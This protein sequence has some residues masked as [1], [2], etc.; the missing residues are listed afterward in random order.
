[1]TMTLEHIAHQAVAYVYQPDLPDRPHNPAS[2]LTR[3]KY[4][5]RSYRPSQI[6][7]TLKN[8]VP[9][10]QRTIQRSRSIGLSVKRQMSKED[11]NYW[12]VAEIYK[13]SDGR[14]RLLLEEWRLQYK[15]PEPRSYLP[16]LE[17]E[18]LKDW[19][20]GFKPICFKALQD[21]A[22]DE[23][24]QSLFTK[25]PCSTLHLLQP[26]GLHLVMQCIEQYR[27]EK[28]ESNC[29]KLLAAWAS[30]QLMPV[31]E[32]LLTDLQAWHDY[33]TQE[34]LKLATA[35][36]AYCN[37][38]GSSRALY[39][40]L[41]AQPYLADFFTPVKVELEPHNQQHEGT[42]S[43]KPPLIEL[44]WKKS[45]PLT[46]AYTLPSIGHITLQL[47]KIGEQGYQSLEP[48]NELEPLVTALKSSTHAN[49][50]MQYRTLHRLLS[51][52]LTL[53]L[54]EAS[55]AELAKIDSALT[56]APLHQQLEQWLA[57]SEQGI[58]ND[59]FDYVTHAEV[60][61]DK[62]PEIVAHLEHLV[63]QVTSTLEAY[64]TE[65]E[66]SQALGLLDQ[67]E[68]LKPF[69]QQ[70]REHKA[71]VAAYVEECL[72]LSPPDVQQAIDQYKASVSR[73]AELN[74]QEEQLPEEVRHYIKTLELRIA[75]TEHEADELKHLNE[76]L[77]T[78][79]EEMR[80]EL[81]DKS[82]RLQGLSHQLD[83]KSDASDEGYDIGALSE[84]VSAVITNSTPT[85]HVLNLLESLYPETLRILPAALEQAD[86]ND[87]SIPA[88]K[89]YETLRTLATSGY[90]MLEE[91]ARLIDLNSILPGELAVKES[92]TV[93]NC[94][95]LKKH[96]TFK[97]GDEERVILTHL[98]LGY[99]C[100]LYFEFDA[101]EKRFIVAYVGPHLPTK[102]AATI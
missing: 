33:S 64:A 100:R 48:V 21:D 13:A 41:S 23:L 35:I 77:K 47:K 18:A 17:Y 14:Q 72:A 75:K 65:A 15:K 91:G 29:H 54:W 102:K 4:L 7:K 25:E 61:L 71:E 83:N 80:S 2:H 62:F 34:Q 73:Q 69:E 101:D 40:F 5:L 90:Q 76:Q 68:A 89:L 96:R 43:N 97:D 27:A 84:Q 20:S 10:L 74:E 50:I 78:E 28:N 60:M 51:E 59:L 22:L 24:Y 19:M 42:G 99:A 63:A 1:M 82:F 49:R 88:P 44:D 37:T 79:R 31:G 85:S 8:R 67:F 53:P 81:N 11:I 98:S 6:I 58:A 38:I 95:K 86:K 56:M 3:V 16:I 92:E 94:D 30:Y 26:N 66:A 12:L 32:R 93:R 46:P 9:A 87:N 57:F 39:L 36:M 45:V 70:L 52:Q 55:E